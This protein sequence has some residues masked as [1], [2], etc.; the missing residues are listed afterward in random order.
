MKH[1][2]DGPGPLRLSMFLVLV[3][4]L[5]AGCGGE[6]AEGEGSQSDSTAVGQD[7]EEAPKKERTLKVNAAAV[8]QG[9]LV[10]PVVAEGSVRSRR[11]AELKAEIA[12]RLDQVAVEEGQQVRRGQLLAQI[13]DRE[14]AVALE[15]ANSRYLEALGKLAADDEKLDSKTATIQLE[16]EM[17]K[18]EKLHKDGA[19]TLTEMQEKQIALEVS[20]VKEG[21]YR[22][23][24]VKIRSGLT[25]AR[26]AKQRAELDL[27]RTRV[28]APF[29]GVVSQLDLT[30]GERV[31][32][33]DVI[34]RLVD[35]G[36]LEADVSVLESDLKGLSPGRPVLLEI[37]ALEQEIRGVVDVMSPEIDPESRTCRVL[38]RFENPDEKIRPGMFVRASIAGDV[39]PETIM[40]PREAILTRDG[41]P[42]VFKIDGERAKWVYVE[43]GKMNDRMVGIDRILQGGPL[44][45]GT[46]VVVS[47]HLTLTHDAKVKVRKVVEPDLAWTTS[48][49]DK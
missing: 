39:F 24:L 28:R 21:A 13:D 5:A 9:D 2:F 7:K 35:L 42:L 49:E 1:L 30:L 22:G 29:A 18:L 34:C 40:V 43:L 12:G 47:D 37:P 36:H 48:S 6:G 15:E 4:F 44:E 17:A 38:V 3:L 8:I 32:L 26:A 10:I 19:I 11:Q 46:L 31:S 16:E 14:I 41:R 45:E 23:E 27:E 33:G 25:D 20:A